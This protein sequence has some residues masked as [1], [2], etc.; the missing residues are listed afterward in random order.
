MDPQVPPIP[1]PDVDQ[2]T[3]MLVSSTPPLQGIAPKTINTHWLKTLS[4]GFCIVSFCIAVGIGGYTLGTRGNEQTKIAV[5]SAVKPSPTYLPTPPIQQAKNDNWGKFSQ[6]FMNGYQYQ[7]KYP[8]NKDA[9][10]SMINGKDSGW[11]ISQLDQQALTVIEFGY[12]TLNIADI[13]PTTCYKT[14]CSGA[15][16][17]IDSTQTVSV[18]GILSKKIQGT[19]YQGGGALP[20]KAPTIEAYIIP[21]QKKYFILYGHGGNEFEQFVSSFEVHD[22]HT[23]FSQ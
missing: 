9:Y 21:F 23:Q 15:F 3:E 18:N 19:A 2:E 10:P 22:I 1:T 11:P 13:D 7:V 6:E 14:T 4:I 16:E 20:L 5:K 8:L 17:T 12:N